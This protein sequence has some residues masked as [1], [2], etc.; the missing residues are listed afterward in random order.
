ML[1]K[2]RDKIA[3]VYLAK[4]NPLTRVR[5]DEVGRAD[6][7]EPR[8]AG[9]DCR[10]AEG[11]YQAAWNRFDNATAT[12]QPVGSPTLAQYERVQ[13]PAE[14][15]EGEGPS[16]RSRSAH[17]RPHPSWAKP[18]DVYFKRAGGQWQLVGVERLPNTPA[19]P[20]AK[21]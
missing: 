3:R 6:V 19:P 12:A 13:A 8:R 18:V 20:P 11:G 10:R 14:L 9:T 5:L 4:I 1:I 16:S 17:S 2:R 15:A 21:K 7:R